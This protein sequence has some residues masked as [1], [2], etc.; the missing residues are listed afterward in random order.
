MD[1]FIYFVDFIAKDLKAFAALVPDATTMWGDIKAQET[2]L[3]RL[4]RALSRYFGEEDG[5]KFSHFHSFRVT[6]ITRLTS[7]GLN[8]S[9]AKHWVGHANKDI[10]AVYNKPRSRRDKNVYN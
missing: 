3:S 1:R 9:M 4:R 7:N 10:T 8:D 5:L 6:C 2:V